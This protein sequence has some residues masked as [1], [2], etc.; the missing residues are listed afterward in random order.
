MTFFGLAR[1]YFPVNG[2][3]EEFL[4]SVPRLFF[5]NLVLD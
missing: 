2:H 4:G 1:S 5:A 3:L